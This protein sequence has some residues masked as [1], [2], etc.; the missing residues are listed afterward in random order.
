MKEQ[1]VSDDLSMRCDTMLTHT[2]VNNSFDFSPSPSLSLS[3]LLPSLPPGTTDHLGIEFMGKE[4]FSRLASAWVMTINI[5][6]HHVGST[7]RCVIAL[8]TAHASFMTPIKWYNVD[9]SNHIWHYFV[10]WQGDEQSCG[11]K[12][13]SICIYMNVHSQ[14]HKHQPLISNASLK[15]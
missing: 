2:I 7:P 3:L 12:N 15:Y 13:K 1:Q 11:E 9:A 10:I 4:A 5:T 6:G 14:I 8:H